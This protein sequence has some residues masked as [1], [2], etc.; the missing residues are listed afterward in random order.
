MAG[1]G[2]SVVPEQRPP[3]L[4]CPSDGGDPVPR[5]SSRFTHSSNR[6]GE[7]GRNDDGKGKAAAR[8]IGAHFVRPTFEHFMECH[9]G[10]EPVIID[11]TI[12]P[13]NQAPKSAEDGGDTPVL[14]SPCTCGY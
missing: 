6:F 1:R 4:G 10:R 13:R 2:A 5:W 11:M 8:G 7:Q 12:L 14:M 3:V 9:F